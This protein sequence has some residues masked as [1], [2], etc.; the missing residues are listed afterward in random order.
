[1]K[2]TIGGGILLF[3]FYHKPLIYFFQ[4]NTLNFNSFY[5][6]IQQKLILLS[7]EVGQHLSFYP[8]QYGMLIVVKRLMQK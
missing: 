5:N 3:T 1:M 2:V 7:Y 4:V 8:K 6:L